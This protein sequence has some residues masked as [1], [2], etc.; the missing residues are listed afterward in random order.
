MFSGTELIA[1]LSSKFPRRC[2]STSRHC[3][4]PLSLSP[5][6]LMELLQAMHQYDITDYNLQSLGAL[7]VLFSA[8]RMEQELADKTLSHYNNNHRD[9]WSLAVIEPDRN[10]ISMK[11]CSAYVCQGVGGVLNERM[12]Y[13]TQ[14]QYSFPCCIVPEFSI[15]SQLRSFA[16]CIGQS[17]KCYVVKKEYYRVPGELHNT[18]GCVLQ[19]TNILGLYCFLFIKR[20]FQNSRQIEILFVNIQAHIVHVTN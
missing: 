18:S 3:M 7:Q 10:C 17:S 2:K 5:R 1:L 13:L 16:E 8:G 19:C 9:G 14:S 15:G 6:P 4:S 12:Q 11:T 20:F